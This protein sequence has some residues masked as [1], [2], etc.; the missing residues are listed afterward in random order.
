MTVI[1]IIFLTQGMLLLGGGGALS[2]LTNL[3]AL[4]PVTGHANFII[5]NL[6]CHNIS[7]IYALYGKIIKES[8]Y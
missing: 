8:R 7:F 3:F 2:Q 5:A 4:F 1:G 6:Y